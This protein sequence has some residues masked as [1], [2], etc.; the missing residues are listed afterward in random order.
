MA[1]PYAPPLP[2]SMPMWGSSAMTRPVEYIHDIQ[3]TDVLCGR[4][5]ATNSH[6]GN[7]EF[8]KL[9]E[10]KKHMYLSAKKRDKPAVASA[11]VN[12]VRERGGRFLKRCDTG[13]HRE[14]LWVD[15]GDERA[16]EKTCQALREG[17]P[18][19]RRKRVLSSSEEEDE[20]GIPHNPSQ[21]DTTSPR[22]P[23]NA[24]GTTRFRIV[25]DDASQEDDGQR[26]E[27]GSGPMISRPVVIQPCP[28]LVGRIMGDIPLASLPPAKQALYLRSFIPPEPRSQN[29]TE[30]HISPQLIDR[31]VKLWGVAEV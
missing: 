11:I 26:R 4:G 19:L 28:R 8:R 23:D 18:E 22:Q 14:T 2:G 12:L 5:G 30:S 15:I 31:S 29:T 9:V 25:D 3:P 21:R 13:M 6:S 17:A 1:Y 16:R 27:R 7:R 24:V 10:E 20:G